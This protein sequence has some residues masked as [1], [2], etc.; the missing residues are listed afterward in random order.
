M[1][2][3]GRKMKNKECQKRAEFVRKAEKLPL[4]KIISLLCRQGVGIE[5]WAFPQPREVFV[6]LTWEDNG[7]DMGSRSESIRSALLRALRVWRDAA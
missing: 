2:T 1:A 6:N 4:E 5:I 7:T 3:G